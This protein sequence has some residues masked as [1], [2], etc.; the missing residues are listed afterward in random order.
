M[1]DVNLL[2]E[3]TSIKLVYFALK[4]WERFKEAAGEN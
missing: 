3:L 4:Q 2:C 1:I